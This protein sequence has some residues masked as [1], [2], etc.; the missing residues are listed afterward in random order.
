MLK[1]KVDGDLQH[2]PVGFRRARY[3]AVFSRGLHMVLTECF[4]LAVEEGRTI[5]VVYLGKLDSEQEKIIDESDE[6][7]A[8]I[9]GSM[10]ALSN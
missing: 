5:V 9:Y 7:V 10:K 3:L 2:L 4:R 8:R 1:N 6:P